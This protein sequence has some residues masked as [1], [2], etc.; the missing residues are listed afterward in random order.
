LLRSSALVISYMRLA[1]GPRFAYVEIG[2]SQFV[3]LV[4]FSYSFF[5]KGF[6]GLVIR[7]LCI[8]T[9][10]ITMQLTARRDW[11]AVFPGEGRVPQGDKL[12]EELPVS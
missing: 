7:L 6:T 11:E 3:H 4:L 5:F 12:G 1:V 9:L 2:V 10:F 8:A